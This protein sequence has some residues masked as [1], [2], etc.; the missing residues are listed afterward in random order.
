MIRWIQD[1][2]WLPGIYL[3]VSTALIFGG[4]DLILQGWQALACSLVLSVGLVFARSRAWLTALS[5][6]LGTALELVLGLYPLVA[7]LSTSFAIFL[8]AAFANA[9]WRQISVIAANLAGF[10]V[11]WQIA[12]GL[13]LHTAIYGIDLANENGRLSIFA[14]SGVLVIATNSLAWLL[15][16][17]L[18]TRL[19]HVGT[20]LDQAVVS[21]AQRAMQYELADLAARL[22]IA[23]EVTS[24]AVQ[25]MANLLSVADGASFATK[26]NPA[27][28]SESFA[29]VSRHSREAQTELRRLQDL[30]ANDPSDLLEPAPRLD[31]LEA[32]VVNFRQSGFGISVQSVGEPLDLSIGASQAIYR[33]LFDALEN[34]AKHNP[35]GSSVWVEFSWTSEGLQILVKDNGIQ[36]EDAQNSFGDGQQIGYDIADDLEA[37]VEQID[38]P[39]IHAMRQRAK[40]FD[41]TVEAT[42]VPGV[43]FT[44]SVIFPNIRSV[45]VDGNEGVS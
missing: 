24:V 5:F 18:I 2:R 31:S 35:A 6:V 22:D 3:A 9:L 32:L 44:L 38:G 17:L 45:G 25:R 30:L 12:Y 11:A 21:R 34:V 37:L 41:G 4:A 39:G 23:K 36:V 33:I 27:I 29:R 42:R 26:A 1:H 40:L 28:A 20:D 13:P 7:S 8:I 14:I 10:V 15:G 16:R 19:L 43:G